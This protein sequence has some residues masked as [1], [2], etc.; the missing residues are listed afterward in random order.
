VLE[1]IFQELGDVDMF[2]I[3]ATMRRRAKMFGP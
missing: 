2:G 1:E 3:V